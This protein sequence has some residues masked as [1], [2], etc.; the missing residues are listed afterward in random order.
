M[1]P[2]SNYRWLKI[3]LPEDEVFS[4]FFFFFGLILIFL[5]AK[6]TCI[7]L[8]WFRLRCIWLESSTT[9]SINWP[10]YYFSMTS[11]LLCWYVHEF[12]IH[13]TT[14][15]QIIKKDTHLSLFCSHTVKEVDLTIISI[16]V[17]IHPGPGSCP[18]PFAIFLP[19]TYIPCP[20]EVSSKQ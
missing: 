12:I 3:A 7:F 10:A 4:F 8:S 13:S 14:K 1:D 6:Y 20:V 19:C 2:C 11:K 16:A 17:W 5:L 9:S 15:Q 18:P